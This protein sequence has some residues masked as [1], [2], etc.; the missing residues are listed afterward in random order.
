[1]K[2]LLLLLALLALTLCL[3]ACGSAEKDDSLLVILEEGEGFSAQESALRV[4]PGEDAVFLLKMNRGISILSTDYRGK[5]EIAEKDGLT[6]LRLLELHYPTRV[7]LQTASKKG[8]IRYE[9]NGGAA[10]DDS[11]SLVKN[12]SLT[13]HPRANTAL[14][15]DLFSREGYTLS[16]W[17]TQP[18]GSGERVG[19]GSRLTLS[20]GERVLYAQWARWSP[21]EDFSWTEEEDGVTIT[22]CRNRDK[23]LVVPAVLGGKPVLRLAEGAFRGCPAETVILPPGLR[24]IED[25]AFQD[26]AFTELTLF[27]DLAEFSDA[28]F[29]GCNNWK[30]FYINAK[31]APYGYAFRKESVYADKVDLLILAQGKKKLVFYGGCSMWYNLEGSQ[32]NK[33]FGSEYTILN[34]A[35]NGTVNSAV[36][37]QIMA[38]Y[39][40]PGDILFH[41]PEISS[42]F[43]LMLLTEMREDD[44]NFWC[45]LEN[46]YDLFAL[47]DMR[48]VDGVMD[49]FCHYLSMKDKRSDYNQF[50]SDDY[51]TPY[52]DG[53]GCIP[54]Y[55][56]IHYNKLGDKVSVK[57]ELLTG[58]SLQTLQ[59]YYAMLQ[60][61]GIRIYVSCACLNLDALPEGDEEKIQEADAVF[62]QTL[63]GMPGIT[64]ISHQG[65]YLYHEEEFYDSNYHLLSEPAKRNTAL[66]M[67]DL[68]AQMITDGL[69]EAVA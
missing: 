7:R 35:L 47:V 1:M 52:V 22:A 24:V 51:R 60:D 55:R 11:T 39:L 10:T 58:E 54:F 41:T 34:L 3:N 12:Y 19:L 67:R 44:S 45:G 43:Q 32:V 65:D 38:T 37:L 16:C 15:T 4:R 69:W 27:D 28:G 21:E 17:N 50:F 49:S 40:E 23:T 66:W 46:N 6:E 18:D 25:G 13:V 5:V 53:Y 42:R 9:A 59:E 14:G 68:L 29:A 31:E 2:K 64:P 56:S 36:Q 20:G 33:L 61:L 26:S 63:S 57:P 48:T 8:Q 62:R 30:T